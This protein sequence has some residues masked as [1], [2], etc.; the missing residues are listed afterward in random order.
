MALANMIGSNIF[1]LLFILGLCAVARPIPFSHGL[2]QVDFWVA[3]GAALVILPLVYRLKLVHRS[4]GWL[5]V[6][7]YSVYALLVLKGA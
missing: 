2:V 4:T 1:N 5:L 7:A 3:M 6:A